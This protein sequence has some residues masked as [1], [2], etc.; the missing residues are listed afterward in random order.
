MSRNYTIFIYDDNPAAICELKSYVA[1]YLEE[2]DDK[3]V[4]HCFGDYRQ[5]ETM[6]GNKECSCD[7]FFL[8]IELDKG[9]NGIELADRLI[10][11]FPH[12]KIV[13]ITGFSDKYSQAIFM[14]SRELRPYGYITKP[15]DPSVIKR[16]LS[17]V[18]KNDK[19]DQEDIIEVSKGK[20][21]LHIVYSDIL[22]IES[23]R[24]KLIF[25]L[26][27]SAPEEIYGK[28]SEISNVLPGNFSQCHRSYI[29]NIDHVR[30]VEGQSNIVELNNGE[31]IFIGA[32]KKENFMHD[33]FRYKGGM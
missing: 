31:T 19:G 32:T 8:D 21:K 28:I 29:V 27:N 10:R 12:I 24:R 17:L 18:L 13:F 3:A 22:Y 33:F 26:R 5:L 23:Y 30:S 4:F 11:M 1:D 2:T 25:H 6:L 7:V 9:K 14:Q 20:Q 16:I 15:F